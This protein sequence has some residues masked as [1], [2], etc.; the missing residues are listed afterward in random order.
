M[1]IL[2]YP[3]FLD[4]CYMLNYSEKPRDCWEVVSFSF[5]I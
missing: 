3:E 2:N 4:S 1:L 5:F